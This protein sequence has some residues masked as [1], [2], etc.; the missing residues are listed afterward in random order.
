MVHK[1]YVHGGL[2][3]ENS[4]TPF[5]LEDNCYLL[6][7]P[8]WTS[9]STRHLLLQSFKVK[10]AVCFTRKPVG[11]KHVVGSFFNTIS[12]NLKIKCIQE[13]SKRYIN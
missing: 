11:R 6:I 1:Y 13:S 8:G 10:Q 3:K 4:K 9:K 5:Q 2:R 7:Q 12:C